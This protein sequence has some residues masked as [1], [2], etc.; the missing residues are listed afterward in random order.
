MLA[1][2]VVMAEV[3]SVRSVIGPLVVVEAREGLPA[4]NMD[5]I[6]FLEGR[7]VMGQVFE[8]FGPVASPFYSVRYNCES[9]IE[10]LGIEPHQTVFYAPS[11]SQYTHYIFLEQLTSL[12]GSDASWEDN[13]EP[14]DKF[15]D[16]SD[17][18]EERRFKAKKRNKSKEGSADG[19]Q[20]GKRKPQTKRKQDDHQRSRQGQGSGSMQPT[21][22]QNGSQDGGMPPWRNMTP[23]PFSHMGTTPDRGSSGQHPPQGLQQWPPPPS[24]TGDHSQFSSP[25]PRP[26]MFPGIDESSLSWRPYGPPRGWNHGNIN[27]GNMNQGYMNQGNMNG[28][29]QWDQRNNPSPFPQPPNFATGPPG[30]DWQPFSQHRAQFGQRPNFMP[31][32]QNHWHP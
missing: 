4:L 21:T 30:S 1:E 10:R 11:E 24:Q 23:N 19:D 3:G 2:D 29:S 28:P 22:R 20:E 26:P 32:A 25:P 27:H 7:K 16:F 14:P 9:D 13:N 6:L 8:T 17:D 18:E 5:T 15:I 31:G 12:K